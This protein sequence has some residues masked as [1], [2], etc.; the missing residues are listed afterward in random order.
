[1]G[2]KHCGKG[3]IA[4]YE[5]FLLFPQCFQKGLFPRGVKRCHCVGM[6]ERTFVNDEKTVTQKFVFVRVKTFLEKKKMKKMLVTSIFVF[7]R[8]V[9][10]RFLFW[11][12][13]MS[14]LCGKELIQS[15]MKFWEV[16]L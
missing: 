3:E 16:I 2:R 9:F 15:T 8:I 5:Q 4:C 1:M 10:K 6:G 13:L 12:C 7:Y 14:R 11:G